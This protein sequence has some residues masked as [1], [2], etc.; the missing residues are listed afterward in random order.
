MSFG[1]LKLKGSHNEKLK[2]KKKSKKEIKIKDNITTIEDGTGHITS[3]GIDVQGY[4]TN[5]T[6]ELKVGDSIIIF[7]EINGSY[8]SRTV[9]E[10]RSDRS[11]VISSPFINNISGQIPFR[12]KSTTYSVGEKTLHNKE[13]DDLS[14]IEKQERL[15][16]IIHKDIS[17]K[18]VYRVKT[19]S[20][21]QTKQKVFENSNMTAE[22]RL[23]MRSKLSGRDKFC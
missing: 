21:Y 16:R 14:I 7:A 11:A 3:K 15:N 12:I 8:D 23:D 5:F 17:S 13:D 20:T 22:E 9:T 1:K 4:K 18:V 6:E 10:I 2:P 19:G